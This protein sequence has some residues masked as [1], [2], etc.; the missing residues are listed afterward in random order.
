MLV[1]RI[2]CISWTENKEKKL[3]NQLEVK[4]EL[5]KIMKAR[6]LRYLGYIKKGREQQQHWWVNIIKRNGRMGDSL[7]PTFC[8]VMAQDDLHTEKKK[9][10]IWTL[11]H[12]TIFSSCHEMLFLF[13]VNKSIH[14]VY[15]SCICVFI[16]SNKEKNINLDFITIT[17]V[18]T[19]I[20]SIIII[21]C[22]K[23]FTSTVMSPLS[24]NLHFNFDITFYIFYCYACAF[25]ST[26]FFFCGY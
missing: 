22:S 3:L 7:Q 20:K 6:Q 8:G 17:T 4:R 13:L 10:L 5:L 18:S 23:L 9:L 16:I 21:I 25:L 11:C 24:R 14:C 26:C 2:V 15:N 12:Q 19:I 1:Y